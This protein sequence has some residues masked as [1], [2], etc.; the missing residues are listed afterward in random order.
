M[1]IKRLTRILF[2]LFTKPSDMYVHCT[3]AAVKLISPDAVEQLLAGQNH[4]LIFQ[5]D[6][7]QFIL[8]IGQFNLLSLHQ[9]LMTVIAH[10]NGTALG[11]RF[12]LLFFSPD[13]F[14]SP[15]QSP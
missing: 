10:L 5:Q 13:A 1:N 4:S 9:Y 7:Q 12:P 6:L 11:G 3:G 14:R 2:D 15:K 8:F